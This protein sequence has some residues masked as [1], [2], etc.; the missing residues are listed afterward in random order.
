MGPPWRM[1]AT[2]AAAWRSPLLSLTDIASSARPCTW[3]SKQTTPASSTPACHPREIAPTDSNGFVRA[4]IKT[5][6][7]SAHTPCWSA[8]GHC[9]CNQLQINSL[10]LAGRRS[11]YEQRPDSATSSGALGVRRGAESP[12]VPAVFPAQR[13]PF[14]VSA[15][16]H[17]FLESPC[18][19]AGRAPW[20]PEPAQP[21]DFRYPLY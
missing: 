7:R 19:V 3:S 21:L 11:S 18:P 15:Q 14:S 4:F 1:H 10:H 13:Q 9:R 17:V 20:T 12:S 5:L 16:S 8:P 6:R 2:T